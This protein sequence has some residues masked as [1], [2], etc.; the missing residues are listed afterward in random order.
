[1]HKTLA[2]RARAAR[3]D[4]VHDYH[5]DLAFRLAHEAEHISERAAVRRRGLRCTTAQVW[6]Y[7]CRTSAG[8]SY[9]RAGR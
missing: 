7:R 6:S 4:V 1:M 2:A 9:H 8:I 5:D 3:L